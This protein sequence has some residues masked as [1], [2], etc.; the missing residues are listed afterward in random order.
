MWPLR[1]TA[2]HKMDQFRD[3]VS[4]IF[5]KVALEI[6]LFLRPWRLSNWLYFSIGHNRR[7]YA[8]PKHPIMQS[9]R[10]YKLPR[11]VDEV[12]GLILLILTFLLGYKSEYFLFLYIVSDSIENKLLLNNEILVLPKC[13]DDCCRRSRVWQSQWTCTIHWMVPQRTGCLRNRTTCWPRL[14]V[15]TTSVSVFRRC[16]TCV[17][18]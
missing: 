2:G 8:D 3:I 7:T 11:F 13:W 1:I 18:D 17:K 5:S 9:S 10:L 4:I 14:E 12:D 16:R 6:L 15:R